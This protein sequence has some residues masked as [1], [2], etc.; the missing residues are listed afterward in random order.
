MVAFQVASIM[1]MLTILIIVKFLHL[2]AATQVYGY[3][4]RVS[5]FVLHMQPSLCM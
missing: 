1:P 4:P 3:I 2:C 5:Y